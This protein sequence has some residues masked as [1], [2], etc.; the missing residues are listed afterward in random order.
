MKIK[1]YI[2]LLKEVADKSP[3]AIVVS[4]ADPEGNSY[5]EVVFSPAIFY[6]SKKDNSISDVPYNGYIEAICIN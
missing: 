4:A 1:D 3:D 5:N 2:K 6:Y